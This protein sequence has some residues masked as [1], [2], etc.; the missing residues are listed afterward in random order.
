MQPERDE[1]IKTGLREFAVCQ[2]L[3]YVLDLPVFQKHKNQ[4]SVLLV[5]SVATGMCHADSDVDIAVLCDGNTYRLI[6]K[7]EKWE[8]GRPSETKIDGIQLHYYAITYEKIK[9]RLRQLDDIYLYVYSTAIVL[10]DPTNAY[11]AH[12]GQSISSVPEVRETRLEGKLDMLVR[13]AAA[14]SGCLR[15]QDIIVTARVCLEIC[16]L[17]LKVCALLDNVGFDPRKRLF[18]MALKGELGQSLEDRIRGLIYDMGNLGHLRTSEDFEKFKFPDRL[19]EI[20]D[21]LSCEAIKN[22]FRVGLEKPDHRHLE[23]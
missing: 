11:K 19:L 6:P 18:T 5:G 15:Q 1:T 21:I 2:C 9:D 14:L 16:T 10:H 20:L 8:K 3:P 17:C 7:D 12:L 22:G 4:L 23:A 13:R